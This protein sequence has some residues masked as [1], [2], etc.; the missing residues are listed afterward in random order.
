MS[1]ADDKPAFPHWDGPSG[2][3]FNGL[4]MRAYIATA[5]LQGLLAAVTPETSVAGPNGDSTNE[6][7]GFAWAAYQMADSMLAERAK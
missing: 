2:R 7:Q 5:A 3:C 1:L 4:T 6:P